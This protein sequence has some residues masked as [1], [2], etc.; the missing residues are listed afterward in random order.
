MAYLGNTPQIGQ[1]RKMDTPSFDGTT[2]T[3]P[4]TID[5]TAFTPPT[6]YAMMVSLNNVIL[7][8]GVGFSISGPNISFDSPPAALTPF[9]GLIF[10][11]TLYTGTPSDGTV[12]DSKV[13][14]GTISYNKFSTNT[15]A[16]LTANQIIFGV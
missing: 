2:A 4:I 8:P 16:T 6:S 13:A 10:G 7:N 12:T 5:G 11:D 15:K 14:L 3:F 1:Y 9:F